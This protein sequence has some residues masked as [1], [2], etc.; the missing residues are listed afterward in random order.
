MVSSKSLVTILA[1]FSLML[2]ISCSNNTTGKAKPISEN[3]I[4]DLQ[5]WD[6]NSDGEAYLIGDWKFKWLEDNP[7]FS[8]PHYDDSSWKN[9]PIRS[10]WSKFAGSGTGY[11]WYRLKIKLDKSK[12]N[13]DNS[14]M[15]L[16]IEFFLTSYELYV[17]GKLLTSSGKFG[18]SEIESVP[19]LIPRLEI[20]DIPSGSDDLV[21]AVRCSNFH[22][23]TGGSSYIPRIGLYNDLKQMIWV[24]DFKNILI[25]GVILMMGIYHLFLWIGRKE[26][27]ASF[28]FTTGCFIIFLRLAAVNGFFVIMFPELNLFEFGYKIIYLSMPIA[29]MSFLLFFNEF[30]PDDF[31]ARL[32]SLFKMVFGVLVIA[33]IVFQCKIYSQIASVYE[34]VSFLSG[35]WMLI[36]IIIAALKKRE[37]AWYMLPGCFLLVLTGL[38]DILMFKLFINTPEVAYIGLTGLIFFQA[39]VLSKRFASAFRTAE[40]LSLFLQ[41]EVDI[42]TS[43]LSERTLEAENSR[44]EIE[45]ANTRL[46]EMDNYKSIFF[47]NITHEFRTPLTLIIGYVERALDTT[48]DDNPETLRDRYQIILSNARRLLRLINQLLDISKIDSHMMLLKEEPVDLVALIKNITVYFES[49]A[50]DKKIHFSVNFQHENIVGLLDREKIENILYNILSNAFK[51]TGNNG[52]IDVSVSRNNGQAI[53]SVSDSGTGIDESRIHRIFERFYQA[54]NSLIRGYEGTGIGLSLVKEYV[55]LHMGHID[56]QSSPGKG[57]VFTVTLPLK[58]ADISD[59]NDYYTLSDSSKSAMVYM[60]DIISSSETIREQD[61]SDVPDGWKPTILLVEDNSEMRKFMR[62]ILNER[63]IVKEAANGKEALLRLFSNQPDLIISDVMMPEM[64]GY[65]L[66]SELKKNHATSRIPVI[67]LTAKVGEDEKIQGLES[68]ADDYILKPFSS[69]ELMTRT[70]SLIRLYR[71]Q[72]V[73]AERNSEIEADLEIARAIQARLIMVDSAENRDNFFVM[74]R[75][76]DKVAGDFY[77]Y[78]EDDGM[79][80]IFIADVS[81]H[82]VASAFLSLVAKNELDVFIKKKSGTS[83]VL[84]Q[85][86]NVISKYT[87]KENFIT[88]FYC[89]YDRK[90]M[91]L[92]FSR[93]GHNPPLLVSRQKGTVIELK[94][95]GPLLGLFDDITFEEKEIYLQKGDRLILY[96]DGLIEACNDSGEMYGLE[97]LMACV[98]DNDLLKPIELSDKLMDEITGCTGPDKFDDDVTLLIFDIP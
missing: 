74:Y 2:V 7:A 20:I 71:Y 50:I 72:K 69:R 94:S 73:L 9:I 87:V 43:V 17:N 68:G 35:M 78:F 14:K 93:A 84:K 79:V 11:G 39:A 88:A 56:V 97:R 4:I 90:T 64:D 83:L 12:L 67:L 75:P 66:L 10:F 42:K 61:E 13:K 55:D 92:S 15:S 28:Y 27:M 47:Q 3:G 77:S 16:Y 58:N 19:Q 96:T 32:L 38:N 48:A 23:R 30:F 21:I 54:D 29:S 53:I 41:D 31:N 5:N 91:K 59:N 52:S 89:I 81:G 26:D 57:S 85:L 34:G 37:W 36:V 98:K 65:Q 18:K 86:N 49:P 76:L 6:F 80:H 33:V 24:R 95:A 25:L 70:E 44:R 46:K 1:S 82:G 45:I 8:D 22:H 51:F 60:S 40:H 62:E 63:Y